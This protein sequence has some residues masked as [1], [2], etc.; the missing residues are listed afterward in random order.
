MCEVGLGKPR[1]HRELSRKD[2]DKRSL[3]QKGRLAGL[4]HKKNNNNKARAQPTDAYVLGALK[5][6]SLPKITR[7]KRVQPESEPEE[8]Y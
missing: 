4:M 1:E 8:P 6:T 2:G 7:G 3:T 5:T